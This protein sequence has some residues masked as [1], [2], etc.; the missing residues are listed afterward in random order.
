MFEKLN[1]VIQNQI[2]NFE[3]SNDRK[4]ILQP[5]ID[6]IQQK[7][8]SKEDINLNFICT[9][10]SRRSHLAQIWA[11]TAASYY[12]IKNVQ[13]Y[14]GG[15]KVTAL[16]P[17]IIETLCNQGFQTHIISETSNPVYAIKY[18]ENTI[19]I[20]GFSKRYDHPYNPAS[21][22]AAIMTCS[23]VEN[24]CPLIFG[25]EKSFSLNYKDPKISD[26]TDIQNQIY[27]T[28][29]LEIAREIFYI[30]NKIKA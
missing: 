30:F 17:K 2:L 5:L 16:F 27:E 6:Y 25:S 29:S 10:N 26:G 18:D 20:I 23:Q 3:I 24:D 11:K 1:K 14:S 9:H 22:F 4:I 15:T 19:P 28:R 12:T 13:S 21:Q 8:V 7:T